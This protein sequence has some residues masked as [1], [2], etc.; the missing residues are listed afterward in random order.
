[1][2]KDKQIQ[3]V[4]RPLQVYLRRKESLVQPMQVVDSKL[5][6][7]AVEVTPNSEDYESNVPVVDDD[8]PIAIRKGV[9]KCI[10]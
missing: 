1:M 8:L 5:N 3:S 9:R 10:Q 6:S 4:T 2:E 7:G